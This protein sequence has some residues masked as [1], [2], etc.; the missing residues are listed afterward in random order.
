MLKDLTDPVPQVRALDGVKLIDAGITDGYDKAIYTQEQYA[1]Q[2]G[3]SRLLLRFNSMNSKVDQIRTDGNNK[4]VLEISLPTDAEATAAKQSISVCPVSKNW[5]MLATW[6]NAS[7]FSDTD[8]WNTPG[9]D[10]KESECVHA[11]DQI[12]SSLKFDVTP[13]FVNYLQA[14]RVNYGLILVA[15]HACTI[16]GEASGAFSPRLTWNEYASH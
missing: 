6:E 10:Y 11:Y 16:I 9:G 4:V 1:L 15:D 12:G 14:R 2:P 13:W 8:R 7:P 5:M 3:Q